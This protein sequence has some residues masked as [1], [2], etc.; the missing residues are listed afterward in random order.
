[1][2]IQVRLVHVALILC[3][4]LPALAAPVWGLEAVF[5]DFRGQAIRGY[6]PVAYF[7]Q[8]KAVKGQDEYQYDWKGAE[9]YFSSQKNKEE[10]ARSPKRYAPQYGGYCAWAVSQGYTASIDPKAWYIYKGKLYLNYSK[11][12]QQTW[13]K[14]IPGNIQKADMNWPK[15][16]AE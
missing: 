8:R 4:V 3:I 10:F 2:M 16:L 6:D 13:S 15:L 1:M 7:E 5:T 12:V 9:W 14:D 11:E